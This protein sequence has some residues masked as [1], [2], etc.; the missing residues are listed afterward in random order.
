MQCPPYQSGTSLVS[1]PGVPL[2]PGQQQALT[3]VKGQKRITSWPYFSKVKFTAPTADAAPGPFTYTINRGVEVRAFSYGVQQPMQAGG[4]TAADG[5][6]TIADTNLTVAN[7]STGGQNVLVHGIALQLMPS[8][9][10]LNDG[11]PPPRR[12]RRPDYAFAA[13][14]WANTSVELSLNGDEN[15]FRLGTPGMV[16]GAGGLTGAGPDI[17]GRTSA[18]AGGKSI[19]YGTNGWPVRSNYFKM[20]AGLIWRNQGNADSMLNV[21]FTVTNQINILS[22]GSNENNVA[23]IGQDVA[24]ALAQGQLGYNF[25]TELVCTVMCF[26]VGEVIGP[27]TRSA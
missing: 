20:P 2:T 3:A 26:L 18:D 1:A 4:F 19:E 5:N 14:L 12:V 25:P 16:P 27:R 15:R 7:Q 23:V 9:L 11:Q 21:I 10:H 13:A 6:A 17:S 24:P 8:S 22:G